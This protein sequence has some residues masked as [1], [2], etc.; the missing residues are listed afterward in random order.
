MRLRRFRPLLPVCLA[1]LGL[2]GAA[3]APTAVLA[4]IRDS[5]D[6]TVQVPDSLRGRS[7]RLRMRLVRP[8]AGSGIEDSALTTVFGADATARPGFLSVTD[9]ATA[10]TFHFATLL[11]FSARQDDG[12]V[13]LYRVGRWPGES[14]LARE[15]AASL[16]W[17]FIR[18][19]E[20]DSSRRVS[21]HFTVGQFLNRDQRGLWPKYLVLDERL[22]DKLELVITELRAAGHAAGGL[23]ILSG[24]RTPQFNARGP[25]SS[26][27]SESRHQYGDAAD[28]LLDADGDGRMD[29][30]TRDGLVDRRDALAFAAIVERVERR[31]PELVGGLGLYRAAPG[32][33]L[34]LHL[35]VRG[36]RVRWGFE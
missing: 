34:F 1:A 14:R 22:V 4:P 9:Q 20:G 30:L 5:A 15:R 32:R 7:G 29:D 35:D 16:P 12:R 8:G 33:S 28:V 31:Y 3:Q 26:Q 21:T 17:G 27:S 23:T 36:E 10:E 18:V 11:P 24:F 25:N 2:A 6:P 13:G 19:E